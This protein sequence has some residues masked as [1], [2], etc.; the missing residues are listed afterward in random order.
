MKFTSTPLSG[1]FLIAQQRQID[2]R[3]YFSRVFC[4]QEFKD[5]GL[6]TDWVQ[7]SVS[8]NHLK[9]TLRG[10]HYQAAPHGEIKLVRCTRGAIYDVIIDLRENSKTFQQWLGTELSEENG[11]SLYIP[12]GFAHGFITLQADS[13]V[14]Y[15]M[16]RTYEPA[17]ARGI[18]WDDPLF[19]ID[20]TADVVCIS[21]K[22]ANLEKLAA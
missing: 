16:D 5:L 3:G 21:E 7:S 10:L 6:T 13:E 22:D 20:W 9:G 18:R 4:E 1:A 19:A 8:F 15:Q 2:E 17:A 11:A 14:L 12:E